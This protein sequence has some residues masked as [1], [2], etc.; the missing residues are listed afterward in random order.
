MSSGYGRDDESDVD[1]EPRDYLSDMSLPVAVRYSKHLSELLSQLE[2][3][4]REVS[5]I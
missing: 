1:A 2:L 4:R 5:D 3:A